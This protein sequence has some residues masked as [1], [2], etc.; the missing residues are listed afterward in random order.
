P[1]RAPNGNF[2]VNE[3]KVAAAK[4]GDKAKPKPVSLQGAIADFSQ[5]GWDVNGAIDG[6][7]DTGWAVVP[8][9]G[10]PHSAM[11]KV[12]SSLGFDDGTALMITLD[13]R[14]PGKEHN[15]GKFR[16]S[17]T[18]AKEPL[19]KEQLP[20]DVQKAIAIP[21]EKRTPEQKALV[22]NFYR[23]QD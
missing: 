17:V 11:F 4:L 18:T 6:N 23:G 3:F 22:S 12:A 14:W 8:E 15:L 2:V 9:T 13:Q 7:P 10:K 16:V 20:A 1:G 21:I 19:L 5:A